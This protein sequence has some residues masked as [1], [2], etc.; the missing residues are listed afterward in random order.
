MKRLV[1]IMLTGLLP[2]ILAS[3]P[4]SAQSIFNIK[5]TPPSPANLKFG[6]KVIISFNYSAPQPGGVRIFAR[7]MT[8]GNPTPH[9]AASGS[10]LYPS[11]SGKGEGYFTISSG[12]VT[13]DQIRFQMYN[14][15][16][17]RKL[18]EV[19]LPVKYVFSAGQFLVMQPPQKAKK[20]I[21]PD[22]SVR[23]NRPD[24]SAVIID[25]NGQRTIIAPDGTMQSAIAL[26]VPMPQ[27]PPQSP[28]PGA[29]WLNQMNEWI[30]Y[31]GKTLLFRI[32]AL[33]ND[34]ISMNHY[35]EIEAQRCSTLYERVDLRLKF[36][37]RLLAE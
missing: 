24:G 22:G 19:F 29:D 4:A 3:P 28:N 10:P 32:Q 26:Q 15:N 37:E 25:I 11:G 23:I 16:Q 1:L 2:T 21:L 33:V 18:L 36:L 35:R 14:R 8:H 7:P 31:I 6:Q 17:S 13:V 20:Q 34:E 5:L 12:A 27:P 30:D 9:Y